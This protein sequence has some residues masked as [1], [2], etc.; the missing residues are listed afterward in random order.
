VIEVTAICQREDAVHHGYVQQLPPSDGHLVMELGVLGP[1]WHYLTRKL[2]L[3]GLRGLAILPGSAGVAALVVQLERGVEHDALRVGK[4]LARLNFGQKF[5]YLVDDDI[6]IRDLET[7][8]W[9]LSARVD[10][11]RDIALLDETAAYQYDPA[12]LARAARDGVELGVAPYKCSLAIVDATLKCRVPEIS[13][14]P[15]SAMD[16]ARARWD[17]LGLPPLTPRPRLRRLLDRHGD[18]ST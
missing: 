10:P 14:P 12:V 17:D 6:D 18:S 3:T 9:A 7:V 15:R 8:N 4:A 13:L 11:A 5:I 2:R 16:A 1:L